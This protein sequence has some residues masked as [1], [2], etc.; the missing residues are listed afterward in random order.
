MADTIP[1]NDD[2]SNAAFVFTGKVIKMKAAL[3]ENVPTDNTLIIQVEH[4]IKAP[5]MFETITG[6]QLT[7]R[8]KE[9]P[10]LNE[11]DTITV[12]ANGWIFGETIAVDAVSYQQETDKAEVASKLSLALTSNEDDV[13]KERIDS[14]DMA[15]AGRVVKIEKATVTEKPRALLA[16]G[17]GEESVTTHISEHDPDWHL[18]TI[19]IDEVVKG[20]KRRKRV[21]VLF[22][23]SDDVRWYKVK[24]FEPGEQGIWLLQKGKEQSPKGIAPKLLAAVP[25]DDLYTTLHDSDFLSLN[26]LS[27]VKSLIKK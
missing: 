24:K 14:S 12:F 18:A 6:H 22:P 27:K 13:L 17:P 16:A 20:P 1:I 9:L 25:E 3:M 15:V 10:Q 5:A 26:E 4:I 8:F 21:K 11:G 2:G 7:V 23:K 19:K